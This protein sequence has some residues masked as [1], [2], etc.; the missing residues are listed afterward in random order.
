M[1]EKA[2]F[3]AKDR[4]KYNGSVYLVDTVCMDG[5]EV[6]CVDNCT[7]PED[8]VTYIS[9][10]AHDR[11]TSVEYTKD[12]LKQFEKVLVRDS[13]DDFWVPSFFGFVNDR[14]WSQFVCVNGWRYKYCIPY[15]DETKHLLG[16]DED[17]NGYYK[18]W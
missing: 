13:E 6:H 5:Y 15:N 7:E 8:A 3:K 9:F 14:V 18:T 11:I 4:I 2:R 16:T 12:D 17:Y 1:E 10:N